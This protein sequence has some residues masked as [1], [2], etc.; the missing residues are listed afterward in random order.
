M[1]QN[2]NASGNGHQ[3]WDIKNACGIAMR[4][5]TFTK[6]CWYFFKSL[7][8]Y[9]IFSSNGTV[10]H[11]IKE[12]N[13]LEITI[14]PYLLTECWRAVQSCILLAAHNFPPPLDHQNS[15][16]AKMSLHTQSISFY[17]ASQGRAL[18][19]GW[20]DSNLCNWRKQKIDYENDSKSM[21]GG[22]YVRA[23]V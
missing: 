2:Y 16:Y 9:F 11:F 19:I 1:A 20:K 22:E 18:K 13:S 15:G 7:A 17:S 10:L 23:G 3:H 21:V 14:H 4:N 8:R 6:Y 5:R 12:S